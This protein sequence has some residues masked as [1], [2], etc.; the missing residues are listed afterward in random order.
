MVMPAGEAGERARGEARG[1]Q[2]KRVQG[3]E[4]VGAAGKPEAR[5]G[6]FARPCLEALARKADPPLPQTQRRD[7]GLA[8]VVITTRRK[9]SDA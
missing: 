5:H 7:A 1:F 8:L 9:R 3:G 2:T 4:Q 6:D